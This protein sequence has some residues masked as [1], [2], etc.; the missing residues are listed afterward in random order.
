M[1]CRK[2]GVNI[3]KAKILYFHLRHNTNIDLLNVLLGDG[4]IVPDS[5]VTLLGVVL[6]NRL[7]YMD[8]KSGVTRSLSSV[9]FLLYQLSH[10]INRDVI[11]SAFY[12]CFYPIFTMVSCLVV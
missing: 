11:L 7:I 12:G 6:Y 3:L 10:F 1:V 8:H 9:I 5:C 4:E 2:C